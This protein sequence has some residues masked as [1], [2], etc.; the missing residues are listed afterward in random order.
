MT[1]GRTSR[2]TEPVRLLAV[3]DSD[4]Y[5]KSIMRALEAEGIPAAVERVTSADDVRAALRRG[6]WDAAV[7]DVFGEA[8][9]VVGIHGVP[10]GE[11]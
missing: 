4:E 6:G 1:V 10:A 9:I 8:G 11:E 3:S 7:A 5:A 2:M